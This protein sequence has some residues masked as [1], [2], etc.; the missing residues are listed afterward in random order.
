MWIRLQI[1]NWTHLFTKLEHYLKE[2]ST[3]TRCDLKHTLQIPRRN[4]VVFTVGDSCGKR[5]N[6]LVEFPFPYGFARILRGLLW[7]SFVFTIVLA[8]PC[9]QRWA[10]T[11]SNT[12]GPLS[13]V[14][15]NTAY[16]DLPAAPLPTHLSMTSNDF[17]PSADVM[18]RDRKSTRLNSSH[19]N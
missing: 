13:D 5:D 18:L 17:S 1:C 14:A 2:N 15:V 3:F 9:H 16:A 6:G 19:A 7:R 4:T 8:V 10:Q 11:L 12:D